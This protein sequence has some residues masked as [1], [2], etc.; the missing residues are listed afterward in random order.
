MT[1]IRYRAFPIG[2]LLF[3]TAGIAAAQDQ[4]PATPQ[5]QDPAAGGWRQFSGAAP[6]QAAPAPDPE[7]VDRSGDPSPAPP[8]AN[9]PP[10]PP[11]NHPPA[12]GVPTELTVKP[13]TFVTVRVNEML[14]S[15]RNLAG[16]PFSAILTQPLVADGVV[17]AQRGQMVYG[18]VAAAQ[19]S[20]ADTPSSLSLE[21]TG[22][23]LVDG[24]QAPVQSQLVAWEGG[25]TP[26][27][28]QAGTVIGTT[29]LGAGVGAAAGW[30]TG[31]AIGAGAGLA[32]GAVAALV[33]RNHP[34]VVYPETA[35]TFRINA[36]VVVSTANAPEAFRYVSPNDYNRPAPLQART[37]PPAPPYYGRYYS[38]YY[39]PYP[40]PY[41]YW[42]YYGPGLG[43]GVVIGPGRFRRW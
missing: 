10:A 13:G 34:T 33:T 31:A 37:G 6:A 43:F 1:R 38:P 15:N 12:Y 11:A 18:R 24:T 27:G 21:L 26:A 2:L 29:A 30:G 41:G 17:V 22:L 3:A 7:P 19:K 20:H 35:M 5:T 40:Y 42:P 8:Q 14:N 32:V 9:L 16:D 25:R 28:Q 39:G 36:P 23:T 4:Q